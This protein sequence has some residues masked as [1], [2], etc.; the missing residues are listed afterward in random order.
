MKKEA[1]STSLNSLAVFDHG[2]DEPAEIESTTAA[3]ETGTAG[4]EDQL[5]A[6]DLLEQLLRQGLRTFFQGI[7]DQYLVL[8]RNR[9]G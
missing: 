8:H 7:L 1:I 9:Q 4:D 6:P 2:R 5:T 3:Q